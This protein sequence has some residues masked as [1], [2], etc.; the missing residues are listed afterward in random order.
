[1]YWSQIQQSWGM[2][3]IP[4]RFF[5]RLEKTLTGW[6]IIRTYWD[7]TFSWSDRFITLPNSRWPSELSTSW[8]YDIYQPA[9]W[10]SVPWFGWAATRNFTAKWIV[11]N[12]REWLFYE[13]PIT[14]SGNTSLATNF[15]I[16]S[17]VAD[18]TIPDNWIWIAI[19]SADA[20]SESVIKLWNWDSIRSA[21]WLDAQDWNWT[22]QWYQIDKLTNQK[23]NVLSWW[24][25]KTWNSPIFF[26]NQRF[27]TLTA[28]AQALCQAW[29]F[30]II[31]PPVNTPVLVA[32]N[33]S[34]WWTRL[35]TAA[36]IQL[37]D[38][39]A[40]Y[41]ILPI[42]WWNASINTNFRIIQYTNNSRVPS[43]WILIATRNS[44]N[45]TLILGT[46][47]IMTNWV[48][49]TNQSPYW[50][51]LI[52]SNGTPIAD[53]VWNTRSWQ[54]WTSV[55]SSREDHVHPITK[56]PNLWTPVPIVW[57]QT[58]VTQNSAFESTEETLQY[59]YQVV[60]RPTSI[61]PWKT[62]V[63][64]WIAWYNQWKV[65]VKWCYI[66]WVI[67]A[68]PRPWQY[69]VWND[70]TFYH[71]PTA[72]VINQDIYWMFEVLYHLS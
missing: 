45:D 26:W 63:F 30:D 2:S 34:T 47:Q 53:W 51:S 4:T 33:S 11:L 15:R 38:R 27:I 22:V 58:L 21:I 69:F 29:Y 23:Y 44:D 72:W 59:S 35:F 70:Q 16:V 55:Q 68:N 52:L 14:S 62:I 48:P 56:L 46:K 39:E 18:F 61:W 13:I 49:L 28:W 1:M 40:L 24:W 10:T 67:W 17:Y 6:W 37:N 31:I 43:H 64:P 50:L 57:W 42:W 54:S 9:S 60:V 7:N 32:N 71:A 66:P 36:G 3:V 20:L 5:D 19:K 8:Y 65:V 12:W 41:Y 25:I